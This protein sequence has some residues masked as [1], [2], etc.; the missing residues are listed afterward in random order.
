VSGTKS[1][2]IIGILRPITRGEARLDGACS[3]GP[4]RFSRFAGRCGY[5]A[6]SAEQGFSVD[7]GI[8]EARRGILGGSR[9]IP[10]AVISA[11]TVVKAGRYS[12]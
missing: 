11:R 8:R 4:P 2:E 5:A 10:V 7:R 12:G 9:I 3:K 6:R 1:T